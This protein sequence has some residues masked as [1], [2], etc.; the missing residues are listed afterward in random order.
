MKMTTND[1]KLDPAYKYVETL[2]IMFDQAGTPGEPMEIPINL[3]MNA[4]LAD[5]LPVASAV[6]IK[7]LF[8]MAVYQPRFGSLMDALPGIQ[9]MIQMAMGDKG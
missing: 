8:C 6:R 4:P 5:N 7:M 1:L 9:N 3:I 2:A